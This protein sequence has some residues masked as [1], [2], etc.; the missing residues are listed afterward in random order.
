MRRKTAV[1]HLTSE[2]LIW[3]QNQ[4]FEKSAESLH[5]PKGERALSP[6]H[7]LLDPQECLA[8]QFRHGR[9]GRRSNPLVEHTRHSTVSLSRVTRF[10]TWICPGVVFS[11]AIPAR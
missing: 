5:I 2:R 10:A 6:L 7:D 9:D 4:S 1:S 11:A 3:V 8:R